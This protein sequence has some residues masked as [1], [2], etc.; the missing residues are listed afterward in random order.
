MDDSRPMTEASTLDLRPS[1]IALE[2]FFARLNHTVEFDDADK[3]ITKFTAIIQRLAA[4]FGRNR[5]ACYE[6]VL[7]SSHDV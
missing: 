4:D 6:W 5:H 2:E 3:A 1:F 7:L